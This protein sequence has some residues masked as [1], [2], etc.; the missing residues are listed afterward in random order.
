MRLKKSD[1]GFKYAHFEDYN[2]NQCSIH[3]SSLA[4]DYCLWLGVRNGGTSMH[5]TRKQVKKLIPHLQKF[6][7]TGGL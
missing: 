7:E 6:V 2:G 1:R 3:E 4:T 5:L